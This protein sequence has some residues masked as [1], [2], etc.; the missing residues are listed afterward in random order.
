MP[1]KKMSSGLKIFLVIIASLLATYFLL[2]HVFHL[3][4]YQSSPEIGRNLSSNFEVANKEFLDRVHRV[5]PTGTSGERIQ[6]EL[7]RQGFRLIQEKNGEWHAQ[8]SK[9]GF[10]CMVDW[11]ISWHINLEGIAEDLA[12][13]YQT[14]C[15]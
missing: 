15:L 11:I 9:P 1:N 6:R 14:A 12:T 8:F 2:V 5:F 3:P 4:Q 13:H 10:P 7:S